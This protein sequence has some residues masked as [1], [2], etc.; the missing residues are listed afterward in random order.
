MTSME[1]LSSIDLVRE[2]MNVSYEEAKN[3]LEATGWNELEAIILLERENNNENVIWAK[4][5]DWL[6]KLKDLIHK[7]N[8]T[9]IKVKQGEKILAE[10]PVTVGL[11]GAAVAPY[12]AII[13]GVVALAGRCQIEV[14]RESETPTATTEVQPN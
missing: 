10:F 9:R 8:V 5:N 7:G 12:L 6:E 2:R 1:Q 4:G 13:G 14:E 11:V 3:A